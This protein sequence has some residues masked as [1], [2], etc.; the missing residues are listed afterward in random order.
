MTSR[1]RM[2]T[3]DCAD[4]V[5]LAEFWSRVLGWHIFTDEDPEVVVAPS[6]PLV[7]SVPAML[8]IPVPEGKTAKNRMHLDVAPTG[9][10]RDEEVDRLLALGARLVQDH[11]K[12]DG[13]G[14][15]YLVDPEDNEFCVVR[16]DAERGLQG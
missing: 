2:V 4:A 6:W 9:G 1:I 12:T 14:W 15:V 8:F 10:T 11:R 7:D 3:M 13:S 16:S 5:L